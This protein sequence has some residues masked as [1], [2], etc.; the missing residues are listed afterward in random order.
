MHKATF[1]ILSLGNNKWSS[2]F[3]DFYDDRVSVQQTSML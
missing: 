1:A 3:A 2:R